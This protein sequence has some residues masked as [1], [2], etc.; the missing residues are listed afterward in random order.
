M[1]PGLKKDFVRIDIADA[2]QN[3]LV[4]E[5]CLEA[6]LAVIDPLEKCLTAHFHGIRAQV[7]LG[8]EGL[9]IRNQ[10]QKAEFPRAGIDECPPGITKETIASRGASVSART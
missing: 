7:L 8:N 5:G 10:A 3:G 2:G 1:Q 6:A 4:H 9:S